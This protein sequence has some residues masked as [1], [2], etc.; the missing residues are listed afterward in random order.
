[1]VRK[2]KITQRVKNKMFD[3]LMVIISLIAIM[4]CLTPFL[5][6]IAISLSSNSAVLGGKVYIVPVEFNI[7]SY[8]NVIND[9]SIIRSF[10]FTV[11]LTVLCTVVHLFMTILAAY[12]LSRRN[13]KGKKVIFTFML[14]TMYFGG[15]MIPNYLLVKSLGIR[16]TMWALILPG[17]I[18]TYYV[19]LFKSFFMNSIPTSIEEAAYLDGCGHISMFIKIIMPLSMPIIAT[20]SLFMIVGRWNGFQDALMYIDKPKLYPL[21]L[22]LYQIVSNNMATDVSEAP[23]IV[24]VSSEGLKAATVMVITLPILL[25]YPWLQKYFVSVNIGSIKG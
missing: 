14:I 11:G 13:L 1:M 18:S 4:L 5:H 21:Q 7:M 17:M 25:A 10:I 15:G 23:G 2:Y 6:E 19:I 3:T 16:N 24:K 8:L 20:I 22:K 12:P 9:K